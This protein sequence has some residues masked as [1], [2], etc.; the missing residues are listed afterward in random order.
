MSSRQRMRTNP[1]RPKVQWKTVA[2]TGDD[3]LVFARSLE[4]ALQEMTDNQFQVVS[5]T[6]RGAAVIITGQRVDL[7]AGIPEQHTQHQQQPPH[8][9]R[10]RTVVEQAP[11]GSTHEEVLYH[12][13]EHGKQVQKVFATMVDALRLVN[14]H[15][16]ANPPTGHDPVT[17]VGLTVMHTTTFDITSFPFL[18]RSFADELR[19]PPPTE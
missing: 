11:K 5:Q 19:V 2:I 3:P 14:E 17:P 16:R 9:I 4:A 10:R 18:L 7:P 12:Y 15:L 1:P 8:G 13:V 6:V